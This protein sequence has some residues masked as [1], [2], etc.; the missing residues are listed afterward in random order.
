M[1][2]RSL[3]VSDF[4]QIVFQEI[5]EEGADRRDRA[6]AA[7][8]IPAGGDRGFEN[9]GGE[10]EGEAGDQPAAEPAARRRAGGGRRLK[11]TLSTSLGKRLRPRRRRLGSAPTSRSRRR[12][13][14][15]RGSASLSPHRAHKETR[16]SIGLIEVRKSPPLQAGRDRARARFERFQ[17]LAPPFPSLSPHSARSNYTHVHYVLIRRA[18]AEQAAPTL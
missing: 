4:A 16:R 18:G 6:K 7:D 5:I 10:L 8:F 3:S 13:R 2:R 12:R 14:W 17:A 15:S 1:L 11:R 9:V